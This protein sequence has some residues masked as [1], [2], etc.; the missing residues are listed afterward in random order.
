MKTRFNFATQQLKK[1]LGPK[2]RK[3]YETNQ[4]LTGILHSTQGSF[5]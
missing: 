2:G 4:T 1:T 5:N 3:K